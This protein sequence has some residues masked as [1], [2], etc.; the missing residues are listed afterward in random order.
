[1]SKFLSIDWSDFGKS[2]LIAFGTVFFGGL[3]PI[4]QSGSLPSLTELS[5]LAVAGVGAAI[6][7]L[8]K[9]F[10]TNSDNK[11]ATKEGG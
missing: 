11:L 2:L 6:A 1:M 7:Y 5:G 8:V 10:F 4:F 9:N 3:I